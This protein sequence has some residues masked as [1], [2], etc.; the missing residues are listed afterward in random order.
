VQNPKAA[1]SHNCLLLLDRLLHITDQYHWV[2]YKIQVL[3]LKA[4]VFFSTNN[5]EEALIALQSAL[6]IAEPE[7]YQRIFIREGSNLQNILKELVKLGTTSRYTTILLRAFPTDRASQ[8]INLV[9]E[10]SPRELEVLRLLTTSLSVKEIANELVVSVN[11][12]RSH[13]KS[14]YSK[15]GVNR[16]LDAI[17]KAKELNLTS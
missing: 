12:A 11:T 7:G 9:E 16:R 13:I 17:E 14:I 3:I 10:L 4:L 8:Q 5:Q 2:H 15:M 1:D 6:T